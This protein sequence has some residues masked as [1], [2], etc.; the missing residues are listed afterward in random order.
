MRLFKNLTLVFRLIVWFCSILGCWT[1]K[2]PSVMYTVS[3][4]LISYSMLVIT[5]PNIKVFEMI[6]IYLI[7]ILNLCYCFRIYVIT[8]LIQIPGYGFGKVYDE[9]KHYQNVSTALIMTVILTPY[10]RTCKSLK[11][12]TVFSSKSMEKDL[13]CTMP[14]IIANVKIFI[15]VWLVSVYSDKILLPVVLKTAPCSDKKESLMTAWRSVHF[16]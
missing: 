7:H 8:T 2:N 14:A 5:D 11:D 16:A 4:F 3:N 1:K 15:I 9:I 12:M 13:A 6:R 10:H